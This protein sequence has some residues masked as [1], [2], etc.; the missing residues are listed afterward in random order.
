MTSSENRIKTK[1]EKLC[2]CPICL[3]VFKDPRTLNCQHTFCRRCLEG[4]CVENEAG[5]LS[6]C[7]PTCR[8]RQPLI[9][10]LS[11]VSRI[12]GF[13]FITQVLEIL[14]EWK[15]G[16][17]YMDNDKLLKTE[18]SSDERMFLNTKVTSFYQSINIDTMEHIAQMHTQEY[19]A[20]DMKIKSL[21]EELS[22]VK[23][24]NANLL[25]DN[26][27]LR[28]ALVKHSKLPPDNLF[29]PAKYLPPNEYSPPQNIAPDDSSGHKLNKDLTT[30]YKDSSVTEEDISKDKSINNKRNDYNLRKIALINS[31]R[32]G[33]DSSFSRPLIESRN[34]MTKPYRDENFYN[35]I[36]FIPKDSTNDIKGPKQSNHVYLN[37]LQVL[38]RK[39]KNYTNRSSPV[40]EKQFS[41]SERNNKSLCWKCFRPGHSGSKCRETTTARGRIICA[42]CNLVG[43]SEAK[44]TA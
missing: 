3:D 25:L 7:C 2:Q 33:R 39:I 29:P 34:K 38:D 5:L 10:Q 15:G 30:S 24:H 21:Q 18:K 26:M 14:K 17:K 11:D 32:R 9:Y 20:R 1:L 41:F 22:R 42:R 27:S 36:A 43:H 44:C 31:L 23:R 13:L 35:E 6:L 4:S 8:S 37:D 40:L 19:G 12:T 16:N 28:I